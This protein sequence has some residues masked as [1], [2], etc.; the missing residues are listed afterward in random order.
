MVVYYL[1]FVIGVTFLLAF[2]MNLQKIVSWTYS[3]VVWE[4]SEEAPLKPSPNTG[5]VRER[6]ILPHPSRIRFPRS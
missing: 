1:D 2:R 4:S 3:V 6:E 5:S